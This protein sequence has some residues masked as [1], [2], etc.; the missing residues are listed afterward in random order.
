M[1]ESNVMAILGTGLVLVGM[2][3][4]KWGVMLHLCEPQHGALVKVGAGQVQ[5][6]RL[7]VGEGG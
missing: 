7:G 6:S 2:K 3:G 1:V 5:T 4:R